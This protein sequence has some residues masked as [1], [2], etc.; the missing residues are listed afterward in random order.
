MSKK[1]YSSF[2]S[3]NKFFKDVF[4]VEDDLDNSDIWK[5]YIFTKSFKEILNSIDFLFKS[6]N[7]KKKS[8]ILSGKYGVGKSHTLAVISH[9]LWD[10]IQTIEPIIENIK[11]DADIPGHTLAQFREDKKYF[12]VILSGK[13]SNEIYDERTFDFRLQIAL[14]E[15]LKKYGLFDKISEKSEFDLYHNW[16][17]TQ[18]ENGESSVCLS[19]NSNLEKTGQFGSLEELM[20]ALSDRDPSSLSIIKDLFTQ[21]HLPQ[22]YHIDSVGYYENVLKEL[23]SKDKSIIGIVIY[24][25]EFTTVFEHAGRSNNAKK[26]VVSNDRLR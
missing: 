24:W 6:E 3:L 19:L 13:D 9:L 12:P 8:I 17:K 18:C 1:R 16:L 15:A 5:K 11:R 20:A 21:W 2:V 14:E 4:S 25:D 26:L 10:D 7:F 23:Q 22:P